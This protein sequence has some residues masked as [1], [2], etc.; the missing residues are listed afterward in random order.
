MML[1]ECEEHDLV[2]EFV[3]VSLANDV[4]WIPKEKQALQIAD[5]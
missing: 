3:K 1:L 5:C 2:L 4:W